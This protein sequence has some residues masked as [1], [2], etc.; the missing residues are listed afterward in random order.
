MDTLSELEKIAI[1]EKL[2]ILDGQV[3][4]SGRPGFLDRVLGEKDVMRKSMDGE[5]INPD[6]EE[7]RASCLEAYNDYRGA[8]EDDDSFAEALSK[9]NQGYDKFV[10]K[11]EKRNAV[12]PTGVFFDLLLLGSNIIQNIKTFSS[13]KVLNAKKPAAAASED[14]SK[15]SPSDL[16][17]EHVEVVRFDTSSTTE[18]TSIT[19][20]FSDA[21]TWLNERSGGIPYGMLMF[22]AAKLSKVP[23]QSAMRSSV[24]AGMMSGIS[25]AEAVMVGKKDYKTTVFCGPRVDCD[26]LFASLQKRKVDLLQFDKGHALIEFRGDSQEPFSTEYLQQKRK[27]LQ[28]VERLII[29]A[30]GNNVGLE[31]TSS[32]ELLIS[33]DEFASIIFPNVKVIHTMGCGLGTDIDNYYKINSLSPGQVLFIHSG[34]QKSSYSHNLEI[35]SFLTIEHNSRF[36]LPLPC[37]LIFKKSQSRTVFATILP[38]ELSDIVLKVKNGITI[39]ELYDSMAEDFTSKRKEFIDKLD[40]NIRITIIGELD[41]LGFVDFSVAKLEIGSK[42]Q[43]VQNYLSRLL[44]KTEWNDLPEQDLDNIN[45][46]IKSGFV[47]ASYEINGVSL[48]RYIISRED[49]ARYVNI[50]DNLVKNGFEVN[51]DGNNNMYVAVFVKNHLALEVFGKYGADFN[52]PNIAGITPIHVAVDGLDCKSIEILA[53]YGADLNQKVDGYSPLLRAFAKYSEEKVD[54]VAAK[55]VILLLIAKGA[56]PEI[57]SPSGY[58]IWPMILDK[59][60]ARE[61]QEALAIVPTTMPK[62]TEEYQVVGGGELVRDRG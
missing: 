14:S 29:E 48:L 58:A 18:S 40:K 37:N 49:H 52:L 27:D 60:L 10:K 4:L 38:I 45:I 61:M 57:A 41:R 43:L 9:I 30:H 7:Y 33:P 13:K 56:N 23:T 36:P 24:A 11:F 3:K 54:K 17:P 62:S 22:T 20:K 50:M 59:D 55:N 1:G 15:Y 39:E 2:F 21:I 32:P 25:K 19:K 26:S 46:L 5:Y 31:L 28:K 34:N 16:S 8:F 44:D 51:E 6:D 53:K 35:L 12:N 47:D 42:K